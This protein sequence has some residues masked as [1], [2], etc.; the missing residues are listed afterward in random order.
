MTENVLLIDFPGFI[1]FCRGNRFV[2]L[3]T[4]CNIGDLAVLSVLGT[5]VTKVQY[6]SCYKLTYLHWGL[7]ISAAPPIPLE[8]IKSYLRL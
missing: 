7:V 3:K 5:P 8:F 6:L 1:S 4:S 2:I